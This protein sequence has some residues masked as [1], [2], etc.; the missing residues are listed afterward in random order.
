MVTKIFRLILAVVLCVCLAEVAAA[1]KRKV[2]KVAE[3]KKA[4]QGEVVYLSKDY[5]AI[6][7]SRDKAVENE[8]LLPID[9]NLKLE[10]LR[11]LANL[12]IGDTVAVEFIET[13][14]KNQKGQTKKIRTGTVITFIR[15]AQKKPQTSV[16]DSDEAGE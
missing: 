14:E 7:Y 3:R 2:T 11:S 6:V 16:L 1:Q 9:K 4:V 8:I 12:K 5:I 15:P 10:H 13:T